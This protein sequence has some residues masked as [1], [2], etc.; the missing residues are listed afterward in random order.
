MTRIQ[1]KIT[2]TFVGL[3]LIVVSVFALLANLSTQRYLTDQKI[4]DLAQ[5]IDVLTSLLVPDS[6]ASEQAIDKHIR[7]LAAAMNLRITLLDSA[8]RVLFDSDVPPDRIAALENHLRRPEIQEA[9]RAAFGSNTRHSATV[10]Q[11]FVYV[12][13]LVRSP[14]TAGSLSGLK[15][16]RLS[17]HLGDIERTAREQKNIIL[18]TGAIVLALV[19]LASW[20]VSRRI[21]SPMVQIADAI[22]KI[23]SGD[24]DTQIPVRGDDEV[25]RV[26]QAV[27]EMVEKLKA[28]IVQLKKLERVR[29]EF[30]GNVSHELRT[31][32]FSLQGFLE[33]LLE[34]AVDDPSVNRDFLRK[35]YSHSQR[36]NSL[37]GDL[38]TISH[39]ESGEMKM[40]FRYFNLHECLSGLVSEVHPTAEL[41]KVTL[42]LAEGL[43]DDVE[44]LGDKERLRVVFE[45]LFENAIKY[46]KPNGSVVV[47]YRRSDGAVQVSITDTGVG[48]APEHQSRI[49][50]RFYRV[51]RNRSRE[52]GG[53]GLGLAIVKHIVEAHGS[54]IAVTSTVGEGSTFEFT[55]K[56]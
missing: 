37:L 21:S 25:G 41:N 38:I 32:I 19:A 30:L 27:N 49:F 50:E 42:K 53:T 14:T 39:I 44:V 11:D 35:A 26:A 4:Q 24:L 55:L 2:L 1:S 9:L 12:A 17:V 36:L 48:V 13:K 43:S 54:R 5:R 22:E 45:N 56:S 8:G 29:S 15:F 10:D 28:D 20:F 7:T 52:V 3:T 51:D 46:N 34:G 16:V 23:R 33:T 47:S 31:P 40:S 6:I 18:F